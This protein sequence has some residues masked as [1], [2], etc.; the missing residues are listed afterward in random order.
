MSE[1]NSVL[2]TDCRHAYRPLIN[3]LMFI[4]LYQCRLPGNKKP[5]SYDPVTGKTLKG[6]FNSCGLSR[7]NSGVCGPEGRHWEPKNTKKHLFLY[8][9]RI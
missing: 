1:N 8:L 3:K 7:M 6:D 5:D 2:C 9:K 4:N